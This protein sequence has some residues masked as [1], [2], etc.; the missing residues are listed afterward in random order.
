MNKFPQLK[1]FIT[2][3][4]FSVIS[5]LIASLDKD[6]RHQKLT[7][8]IYLV[9]ILPV[10]FVYFV[11]FIKEF[12]HNKYFSKSI[13]QL[14]FIVIL[15]FLTRFIFLSNY[16][17]VAFGDE[18][19]D[20]GL[21]GVQIYNHEISNIFGYGRYNA[22]GLIIPT[23]TSF[24]YPIYSNSVLMYRVPAAIIGIFDIILVYVLVFTLISPKAGFYSAL[25]LISLPLHLFYSRT[26][27]V[28]IFSSFITTCLIFGLYFYFSKKTYWRFI[29]LGILIGL[30]F[31]FHASVKTVGL[32]IL[33][34]IFLLEIKNFFTKTI[35]NLFVLL[36]SIIIGFGPRIMFTPLNIFFHT[37]RLETHHDLLF[38]LPQR[39]FQSLLVWFVNPTQSFF[40]NGLPLL[41][42]PLFLII[43]VG[44][45]FYFKKNEKVFWFN[46][47]L[48]L[49]LSIPF[50]NS[51]I[52][53]GIN[54]DHRLSPLFSISAILVGCCFSF[55][56]QNRYIKSVKILEVLL[57]LYL[58][59]QTIGFYTNKLADI[60]W[61]N[62]IEEKD[63]LSMH[64][65]KLIQSNN[66]L[67]HDLCL[68]VPDKYLSYFN[69]VHIQ[70]QYHFFLPNHSF[71]FYGDKNLSTNKMIISTNCENHNKYK[72]YSYPCSS[73]FDF[74]CPKK[75][76]NNFI[77]FY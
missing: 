23:I 45:I 49:A 12:F 58:S 13:Y 61:N 8:I 67:P 59:F 55:I 7:I 54:F 64:L 52:T 63:Y 9:S 24:F 5:L 3:I 11:I 50:T 30:S 27:I 74:S 60:N 71:V 66:N 44:L 37:S 72:T 69:L 51:A 40:K 31:N 10:I 19:R 16:P 39:Y 25:A 15:A 65:I 43:I 76:F 46:C 21:N 42:I 6:Y 73:L 35:K 36:I 18:V 29:F 26:Q 14:L 57:I 47:L 34:I 75:Y 77:I 33:L 32:T 53:D 56:P 62:E 1:Y 2:I 28:V 41:P 70:E 68:F 22:H 4:I 48:F 38:N 17:F 20:G